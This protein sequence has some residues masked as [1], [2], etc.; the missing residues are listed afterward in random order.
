MP[1]ASIAGA[2]SSRLPVISATM[3]M[4]A[5]GA[6]AIAPK[7]AIIPTT[8]NGAGESGTPGAIGASS[9]QTD[10]P[11][12]A[13]IIMPGP[14]MPPEPPDPIESDVAKILANGS[15][16]TI[17]SGMPSSWDDIASCTQP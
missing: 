6:C 15:A 7:E 12:N 1:T 4:T 9:R 8:T 13:P 5:I 16:S 2:R 14:K 17:H 11:R 10:A 3:S